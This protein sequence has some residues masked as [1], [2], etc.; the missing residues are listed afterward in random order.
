MPDR[1][2]HYNDD[3]TADN[4]TA[5]AATL[6]IG[7]AAAAYFFR[8]GHG[9]ELNSFLI[10]K[11]FEVQEAR[12]YLAG[13]DY[14]FA[15]MSRVGMADAM[16]IAHRRFEGL[17]GGTAAYSYSDDAIL[18]QFVNWKTAT[19]DKN[20]ES[21]F[22]DLYGSEINKEFIGR[23][24][25]S[26]IPDRYKHILKDEI[27]TI[28][29][30]EKDF[31]K[32]MSQLRRRFT[33]EEMASDDFVGYVEDLLKNVRDFKEANPY[34]SF[35]NEESVMRQAQDIADSMFDVSSLQVRQAREKNN[36]LSKLT[37]YIMGDPN[38]TVGQ[39]MEWKNGETREWNQIKSIF[40]RD[41]APKLLEGTAEVDRQNVIVSLMEQIEEWEKNDPRKADALKTL[42]LNNIRIGRNGRV[43]TNADTAKSIR[44]AAL[45]V[46]S[47]FPFSSFHIQDAI[48]NSNAPS[49]FMYKAGD[50]VPEIAK[51]VATDHGSILD[52]AVVFSNGRF[53]EA[54]DQGLRMIEGLDGLDG[55][56]SIKTGLWKER[57]EMGYGF[58]PQNDPA[59]L[60]AYEQILNRLGITYNK[61]NSTREFGN[62]AE[63]FGKFSTENVSILK[64]ALNNIVYPSSTQAIVDAHSIMNGS[65]RY[66]SFLKKNTVGF[67]GD[68][69]SKLKNTVF[70][71]Q[72]LDYIVR[73]ENDEEFSQVIREISGLY[74]N[75]KMSFINDRVSRL[76][77][78]YMENP[79]KALNSTVTAKDIYRTSEHGQYRIVSFKEQLQRE[80]TEEI[81]LRQKHHNFD[82]N[83]VFE[84]FNTHL[85]EAEAERAKDISAVVDYFERVDRYQAH[86]DSKSGID[87]FVQGIERL[88][89]EI[90]S[91]DSNASII[92]QRLEL[93]NTRYEFNE[94]AADITGKISTRNVPDTQPVRSFKRF[95]VRNI[96]AALNAGEY[97]RAAGEATGFVNQFFNDQAATVSTPFDHL[98]R[99]VNNLLNGNLSAGDLPPD[100][101]LSNFEKI[102]GRQLGFG[103][104]PHEARTGG[105]IL[106]NLMLKRVL[107]IW[108]GYQVLD[109]LDDT[110]KEVT[111]QGLKEAG[112]SGIA[113]LELAAKKLTGILGLDEPL[114]GLT[115]DNAVFKYYSGIFGGD[116][117][118]EWK[119]YEEAKDWYENGYSA[120][121][122]S[123]Y[124]TFGSTNEFRGGKIQYFEPNSQR[125]AASDYYNESMY[126]GSFF[127]K[128]N[129]LRIIDPYYLEDLHYND[130]PYPI[131]GGYWDDNTP[132]G[133][134]LNATIGDNIV[135]PRRIMH[136]ERLYGGVDVKAIISHV[137]EQIRAKDRANNGILVLRNGR[138]EAVDFVSYNQPTSEDYYASFDGFGNRVDYSSYKS[139]GGQMD[140]ASEDNMVSAVLTDADKLNIAAAKGNRLAGA[141]SSVSRSTL[142]N[143]AGINQSTR[144]KASGRDNTFDTSQGMLID[145]SFSNHYSAIDKFIDDSDTVQDLMNESHADYIQQMATTTRLISG[146]YGYM[147]NQF[148]GLGDYSGKHIA[149]S[150]DMTSTSRWFWDMNI[151]G[152]GGEPAEA[153]R[154][155]I[156]EFRRSNIVNPLMNEMPEWMPEKYRFGDPYT[157]L[158]GAEARMPGR[159]YETIH[160]L[161]PDI[162]GDYGAFDRYKILADIAPGSNEYK[163][164]KK[165]ASRTVT[166]PKL[167]TEMKRIEERVDMQRKQRDFS[168][169]QYVG[170]DTNERKAY[171]TEVMSGGKFKVTGSEQVYKL[172]GVN[173]SS[174]QNEN[175]E[176]VLRRYITPG[177]SVTLVT[178]ENPYYSRNKDDSINAGIMVG[179]E[180][181]SSMMLEAGDAT[182]RASDIS[183]AAIQAGHR[184]E[185]NV[186]NYVSELLAHANIPIFHDRFLRVNSTLED[187][188]DQYLYGSSFQ[189]WSKPIDTFIMPALRTY[190][191]SGTWMGIGIA[192]DIFYNNMDSN[193]DGKRYIKEQI[194]DAMDKAGIAD[195]QFKVDKFAK[196]YN[197]AA[198]W[199]NNLDRGSLLGNISAE[200]LHY[201]APGMEE[202]MRKYGR[203]I[204][205][206]A[207]LGFAAVSAPE[208]LAVQAMSWS[209]LGFLFSD[210]YY[211]KGNPKAAFAGAAAGA[212]IGIARW[213]GS[214]KLLADDET[215][216]TYIP[217]ETRRRWNFEDYWDRITY[218]KYMSLYNKA[219]DMAKSEEGIDIRRML[220]SQEENMRELAN[221]RREIAEA[222]NALGNRT[223]AEAKRLRQNLQERL[224]SLK[225]VQNSAPVEG[226]EY[227]KSAVM[228]YN[229]AQATMYALNE[230]SSMQDVFRALPKTEREYYLEFMKEKDPSKQKEILSI[231][232]PSL[233]KALKIS[234]YGD[235]GEK[236]ESM[237][238][239][240]SSMALPGPQWSGWNPGIDLDDVKAKVIANEASMN[241]SDFGIYASQ[242]RDPKVINAPNIEYHDGGDG[243]ILSSL[244]VQSILKGYGLYG[245][246]VNV[247]PKKDSTID[248]IANVATIAAYKIDTGLFG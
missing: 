156:P 151:G 182:R 29:T 137:N 219:A 246:E 138:L 82:Y 208:N 175:A 174:N 9:E 232:S 107:P 3:T 238:S 94:Y 142:N 152:L 204:G 150:G 157:A 129:P 237:E 209:R 126:N 119:S 78:N 113:N 148:L 39:V 5:A 77:A 83:S 185:G 247:S 61:V 76:A 191:S 186:I 132:W 206:A 159:G 136:Q 81:L 18:S 80:L 37:S 145:A 220:E 198:K 104:K 240:F 195:A 20:Y 196:K 216:N 72:L 144:D 114:K 40:Q 63:L 105:M 172:A 43:Y 28:T 54:T 95:D 210:L 116:I 79:A 84:I 70:D 160:G 50:V 67:S 176:A 108:A 11:K 222:I 177:T 93:I 13:H 190:A 201:G 60:D 218:L 22:R 140:V 203:R 197:W 55:L 71:D 87:R 8:S 65:G 33:A 6:G 230:R 178:D 121:R 154:R 58:G 101:P 12:K 231:V 170:R 169:Y 122:K 143:L 214:V 127:T 64:E 38:V 194:I 228:Y 34:T 120:I 66:V 35:K 111:G 125:L 184:T 183:A 57:F 233:R 131:S 149:N 32:V 217:D 189:D 19:Q 47:K 46:L 23:I 225:E 241:P 7:G 15:T 179:G 90:V 103:L 100:I 117:N 31:D 155:F 52:R 51:V 211:R 200:L 85:T 205:N 53:Y 102:T 75:E 27:N 112:F 124:W 242:Y 68:I 133:V 141:L 4:I 180:S 123:R 128:W 86:Q 158:P 17:S 221:S 110:S 162:Y 248:V 165:I 135:K 56:V 89:N 171:V 166:D 139:Y 74:G 202:A 226:G 239:Y 44:E 62:N 187:Y 167:K 98:M 2:K 163:I 118:P 1:V 109:F 173:V 244:K 223:D 49:F 69:A 45:G 91:N 42:E 99:R 146:L 25:D 147:G 215:A 41:L 21:I 168:E 134:I 30:G 130:R 243:M 10:R 153:A 96:V 213:A 234:W 181:L 192:S 16:N 229:A 212:A 48:R 224:E 73:L 92:G 227:T 26:A 88:T 36:T 164:W 199:A 24:E 236:P 188:K 193:M 106:K 14:D 115:R 161:H 235:Y 207:A 59:N 245:V 97:E